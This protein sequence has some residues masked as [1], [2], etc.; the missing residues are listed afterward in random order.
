MSKE[1]KKTK[2]ENKEQHLLDFDEKM[3]LEH[4]TYKEMSDKLLDQEKKAEEY[5]NK[6]MTAAADLENFK[7]RTEKDIANAH[8]Y[9]LEKFAG[10]ILVA[11][12]NLERSLESKPEENQDLKDFY[13]GIELTLKSLLEV[14]AKFG[15]NAVDPKVGEDFD[16]EKHTAMS[17]NEDENAKPNTILN[18]VQKG[19]WLKDRLLRPALVVVAK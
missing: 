19:Y 16:P 14:L 18:V 7:R 4:P 1:N 2:K 8:K 3:V 15:I 9:A 10:E 13:V 12:D 11:V 5:K 6:W 17:A